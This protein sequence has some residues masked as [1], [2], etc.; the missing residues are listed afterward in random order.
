MQAGDISDMAT[1]ISSMIN[2]PIAGGQNR[3][4]RRRRRLRFD[5]QNATNSLAGVNTSAGS[6]ATTTNSEYD[7]HLKIDRILYNFFGDMMSIARTTQIEFENYSNGDEN[8]KCSAQN[9]AIENFLAGFIHEQSDEFIEALLNVDLLA[10]IS[11]PSVERIPN[12]ENRQVATVSGGGG[13]NAGNNDQ[14]VRNNNLPSVENAM[15][16]NDN[17]DGDGNFSEK[18]SI[19][20]IQRFPPIIL[21]PEQ[22][23][24]QTS[25]QDR[26]HI[27]PNG[28]RSGTKHNS[29]NGSYVSSSSRSVSPA[30]AASAKS[31][32]KSVSRQAAP[33]MGRI[34]HSFG[35]TS[36][37]SSVQSI[38]HI[39]TSFNTSPNHRNNFDG[40]SFG[41][42]TQNFE[43]P[44]TNTNIDM[45]GHTST[46]ASRNT[47]S[48]FENFSQGFQSLKNDFQQSKSWNFDDCHQEFSNHFFSGEQQ[49]DNNVGN[50]NG[51][52][53]IDNHDDDDFDEFLTN[54][55]GS[56]AF[57][58][59]RKRPNLQNIRRNATSSQLSANSANSGIYGIFIF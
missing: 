41:G 31:S 38:D 42:P 44:N 14:I 26:L 36:S 19:I 53:L 55:F 51:F 46:A 59:P 30:P 28:V 49:N 15:V 17:D 52:E 9:E 47:S 5:K 57:S 22:I 43:L 56:G 6:Q 50:I 8:E 21:N 1:V 23:V 45:G 12:D 25:P 58:S 24:Q 32:N 13:D 18:S 10:E 16:V 40:I 37:Q 2:F 4:R 48:G 27:N 35:H 7:E 3:E 29:S 20:S 11:T 34:P 33:Y 54:S 39:P